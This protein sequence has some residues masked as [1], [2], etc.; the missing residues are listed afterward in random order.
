LPERLYGAL[1]VDPLGSIGDGRWP[2]FDEEIFRRTPEH[3][4]AR[5]RELDELAMA[6]K[7]DEG[8]A[9][10]GMRLV[11]PAYFADPDQAPPMPELQ[12]ASERSAQMVPS[13]LAELPRLEAGLPKIRV[14]VGFVHGSRSPM[15]LAASTDAADRIPGAWV[16]VVDGAGH[17]VWVEA[18]G[19]VRA[20]LRRLTA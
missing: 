1:A 11:W 20:S 14:P 3:D 13:I 16:D 8:L 6:G 18:P 17:F 4:R 10:E 5:A 9:L 19:A 7:A 15:P 2:E 12:I